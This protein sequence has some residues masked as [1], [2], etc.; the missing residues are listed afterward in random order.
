MFAIENDDVSTCRITVERFDDKFEPIN[1]ALYGNKLSLSG[2]KEI[3]DNLEGDENSAKLER[4]VF[5]DLIIN[6][7]G[8]NTI[9]FHMKISIVS[10]YGSGENFIWSSSEPVRIQSN[11]YS[12][13]KLN[14][15]IPWNQLVD[16]SKGYV[17]KDTLILEIAAA[18]NPD[19]LNS[20]GSTSLG[21]DGLIPLTDI[22]FSFGDKLFPISESNI[23]GTLLADLTKDGSRKRIELVGD[24]RVFKYLISY[25]KNKNALVFEDLGSIEVTKIY[26]EAAKYKID[27][28]VAACHAYLG[29]DMRP[30]YNLET[31]WSG[32]EMVD[33]LLKKKI[34]TLIIN[35]QPNNDLQL[36][37]I[38]RYVDLKK[39]KLCLLLDDEWRKD[40]PSM[41]LYDPT[42]RAFPRIFKE[43]SKSTMKLE[44]LEFY[45]AVEEYLEH[46]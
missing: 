27:G 37:Y 8:G 45:N 41:L 26:L 17:W 24:P 7:R 34:P 19:T 3:H 14:K 35:M 9:F 33:L 10:Q 38:L 25:L 6:N 30:S 31:I 44:F 42:C 40:G 4:N 20:I 2:S 13:W 39:L 36:G 21:F 29:A 32:S 28:L 15:F 46:E 16:P 18:F 43:R 5:F 22:V 23:R 1:F 12:T 11:R